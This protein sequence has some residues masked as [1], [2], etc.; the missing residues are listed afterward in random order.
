MPEMTFSVRWPDG[1]VEDCYSPSLVMHDHLTAGA[2]YTV[3][4]L[5]ARSTE[6]LA[7]A[8]DRVRAKFGFACTSAAATTEQLHRSASAFRS[9]DLVEVVR[10]W[11]PLPQEHA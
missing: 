2:T 3:G 6:A 7:I 8:S 10:M 5:V 1:R 4:D 9:E 11:P